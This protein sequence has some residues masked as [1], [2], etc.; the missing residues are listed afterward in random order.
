MDCINWTCRAH[1]SLSTAISRANP[2]VPNAPARWGGSQRAARSSN[3]KDI[4]VGALVPMADTSAQFRPAPSYRWVILAFGILAYSTS[5]F[6]RQNYGGVQK[7]IAA[8]F[9]LDGRARMPGR[10]F[11]TRMPCSRCRG[12]SR[13]T[14]SAT[15][16][17]PRSGSS[18]R[19][20]D[21]G[22]RHQQSEASLLSGAARRAS[23]VRPCMSRW[24]ARSRAGSRLVKEASA[25]RRLQV[26]AGRPGESA[27]SSCC[28]CWRF[29]SRQG[30]GR[31]PTGWPWPS[32]RWRSSASSSCG[33]RHRRTGQRREN[34][35][36]WRCWATCASGVMR[37]STWAS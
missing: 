33:R 31:R 7:L 2:G 9:N 35:F 6:A 14:G 19:R 24:R 26:W 23:P 10:C 32:P 18:D 4:P 1:D 3:H 16:V 37:S 27:A 8:D 36:R 11:S 13:L 21:G 28:R 22:L 20:G 29:I 34:R 25:R 15:A 5:Q 17:S 12:G 30:G